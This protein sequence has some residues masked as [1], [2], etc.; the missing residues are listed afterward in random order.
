M[1]RQR[2]RYVIASYGI[3]TV[4]GGSEYVLVDNP[5]GVARVE[6]NGTSLQNHSNAD[7]INDLVK[8]LN[9]AGIAPNDIVI[10][11]F[12]MAQTRLLLTKVEHGD[13]DTLRFREIETA[14]SFQGKEGPVLIVDFVVAANLTG[15]ELKLMAEEDKD[16]DVVIDPSKYSRITSSVRDPHRINVV[17][18][19]AKDGLI[20]VGQAS[21]LTHKVA[22]IVGN[23]LMYLDKDAMAHN[24][25]LQVRNYPNSHPNAVREREAL[26]AEGLRQAELKEAEYQTFA[27]I[28][29]NIQRNHEKIEAKEKEFMAADAPDDNGKKLTD[30]ATFKAAKGPQQKRTRALGDGESQAK[31][32]LMV[33]ET[34]AAATEIEVVADL[35]QW[36]LLD[37]LARLVV[38]GR[39]WALSPFMCFS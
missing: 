39:K 7:M 3:R 1:T 37:H 22:V 8:E 27:Y 24:L 4:Q 11:S 14:D 29:N 31:K 2:F 26:T 34:E 5:L 30:F 13:D 10:I 25:L 36:Q 16:P 6:E 21:L 18:T 17:L 28:S 33:E 15:L 32:A 38:K 23:A 12:Y 9:G 35:V 20:V 19:R